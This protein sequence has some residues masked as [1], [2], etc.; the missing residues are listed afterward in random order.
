MI[1][2]IHGMAV[3]MTES[4]VVVEAGGIGYEIYTRGFL[5]QFQLKI[6]L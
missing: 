6:A 4:S 2:F 5:L 1:A 3:D